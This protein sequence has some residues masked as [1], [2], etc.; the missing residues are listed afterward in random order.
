[1][2]LSKETITSRRS[3][4]AAAISSTA[5]WGPPNASMAAY[6]DTEAALDVL[7]LWMRFIAAITS[8]GPAAKPMRQPVML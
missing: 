3:L 2:A 5:S 8:L 7:W 4:N 6:C 1:M